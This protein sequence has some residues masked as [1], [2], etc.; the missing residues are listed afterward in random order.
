MNCR[1]VFPSSVKSVIGLLMVIMWNLGVASGNIAIVTVFILPVHEHRMFLGGFFKFYC[2]IYVVGVE[3]G[4]RA[5]G[6][7]R[8][9]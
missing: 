4:T 3:G 8:N 9:Q 1:I 2:F 5:C 6:A 7:F